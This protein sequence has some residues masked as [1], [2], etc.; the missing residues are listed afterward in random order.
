MSEFIEVPE[1]EK[2]IGIETYLTQNQGI[3][4][5]I[6][7]QIEDFQV[8]ELTNRAEGTDGKYLIAELSKQDWDTHHLI[9]ELSRRLQISRKR[10]GWAGTKDKR[11]ITT[12]KISIYGITEEQLQQIKIKD[13][14]LR[15][16]GRSNKKI[17]L[18]DLHG[19]KFSIMIR[20]IEHPEGETRDRVESIINEINAGG[21]PNFFGT[22]RFGVQRPVTHLVGEAIVRGDF[23]LAAMTY[24][25]RAFPTENEETQKIRSYIWETR[26]FKEG[27]KKM[28]TYLRYEGAMLNH[29]I[30]NQDD[31]VGC[32]S[33]LPLNL[34]KMLVHA[35]QSYIFNRMLSARMLEGMPLDEALVGDVVCFRDEQGFPDVRRTQMVKSSEVD[36]INNLVRRSRAFVALPVVGYDLNLGEGVPGELVHRILSELNVKPDDFK[37]DE[38]P[39]LSSRGLYR[40]VLAPVSVDFKVEEDDINPGKI[41][42]GLEFVLPRGSYAT[43]VL[44]EIMKGDQVEVEY[45]SDYTA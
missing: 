30:A 33:A 42:V 18:G 29:L 2:Q 4:G 11:A 35:H 39:E 34:H 36:G 3:G 41:K 1:L 45:T 27:L 16:I 13:V 37:I 23:E 10:I 5:V 26:D 44:R 8:E 14:E 7:Q 19:N 31:Y 38:M 40:E 6:R 22:Q 21:T 28:P 17:A 20:D 32:F 9:T 24:I 15:L 25:A 43:V 12:Q